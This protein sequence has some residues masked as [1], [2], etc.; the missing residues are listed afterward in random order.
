MWSWVRPRG[1]KSRMLFLLLV[2]LASHSAFSQSQKSKTPELYE[3]LQQDLGFEQE[4]LAPAEVDSTHQDFVVYDRRSGIRLHLG[5]EA[6]TEAGHKAFQ[7]LSLNERDR[8]LQIRKS[9]FKLAL[10]ALARSELSLGF[11]SLVKNTL[12][13]FFYRRFNRKNP[14]FEA[15]K[16]ILPDHEETPANI[17]TRGRKIL[18][19]TLQNFDKLLWEGCHTIVNNNE[20]AFFSSL[21]LMV[22]ST[23]RFEMKSFKIPFTDKVINFEKPLRIPGYPLGGMFGYGIKLGYNAEMDSLVYEA[24]SETE[25]M[26]D[27]FMPLLIAI[28]P[29]IG[30]FIGKNTADG[31]LYKGESYYPP[32]AFVSLGDDFKAVGFTTTAVSFPPVIS[33]F[34]VYGSKFS[35]RPLKRKVYRGQKL[36]ENSV[37]ESVRETERLADLWLYKKAPE[38]LDACEL[39]LKKVG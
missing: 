22:G 30:L 6:P 3:T 12:R 36:E 15:A 35:I 23:T 38:K 27:G 11:G 37:S 33:E 10:P 29:K 28:V 18:V 13:H 19:K 1:L 4:T 31:T 32:L 8:F 2:L 24:Y 21:S 7:S 5:A 14:F 16:E 17:R 20:F 25:K 34:F 39:K 26:G 9:F